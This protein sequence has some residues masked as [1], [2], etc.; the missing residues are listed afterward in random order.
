MNS[1]TQAPAKTVRP[2][3]SIIYR[4]DG[5]LLECDMPGVARDGISIAVENNVL[6]ISGRRA[7]VNHGH[8][9]HRESAQRDYSRTFSIESGFDV[10]RISAQLLDGVLRVYLPLTEAPKPRRVAVS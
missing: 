8:P 4:T 7:Q 1:K 5:V 3:A 10:T 2:A 6:T 9:V